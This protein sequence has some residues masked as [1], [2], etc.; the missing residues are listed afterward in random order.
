MSE[1]FKLR[2]SSK[3]RFINGQMFDFYKHKKVFAQAIQDRVLYRLMIKL[4][5]TL[6]NR[7]GFAF[8]DTQWIKVNSSI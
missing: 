3:D 6:R 7:E 4:S 2:L 8:E 5:R 1:M